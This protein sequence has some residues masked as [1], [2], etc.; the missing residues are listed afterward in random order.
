MDNTLLHKKRLLLFVGVVCAWQL[1]VLGKVFYLKVFQADE[2]ARQA[3]GQQED[4]IKVPATRGRI[5]DCRLEPLAASI[6]FDSVYVYT[7]E[8]QDKDTAARELGRVLGLDA[9]QILVKMNGPLKFRYIRRFISHE[10]AQQIQALNLAGVGLLQE[11]RRVY[12][13]GRLA[14]HILGA[15]SLRQDTE[16]GLEGLERQ[17]QD[18]LRGQP[19]ELFIQK[20]GR[21]NVLTTTTLRAPQGGH[22]LI[23]N[24]DSRI[25][26]IAQRELAAGIEAFNAATG[27]VIV[28]E[29]ETGRILALAAW[30][31][32]DP[33]NLKGTPPAN[34]RN[35]AVERYFEPGST[36]KIVTV[37]A[38]LEEEIASPDDVID[39][40][41]GY[42]SLSGHIIRDHR[43][44]QNL[45]FNEVL[46]NSSDVGAIKLGLRVG[47]E[48]LYRYIRTF[49]FG[50]RTDIDLPAEEPGR[51]QHHSG[52]SGISIGAISMGQEVGVTGVQM[53]RAMAV[54]A[55]GG[56]L[57]RPY[58]VDRVLDSQGRLVEREEPERVRVLSSRTTGIIRN[59]LEMVV[60]KGTGKKAAVAGYRVAG[61]TG[62]AQKYDPE[63]RTYSPTEF[64]SSYVGFAPA[65]HP[66]FVIAVIYDSPHPHYHGGDVSAPVFAE[67]ARQVLMLRKVEPTE[68]VAPERLAAVEPPPAAAPAAAP[69][70]APVDVLLPVEE[71]SRET[72]IAL[73][74]ENSF[75]M[76]DFT[77][78][79][80]RQ[81]MKECARIGLIL[82]PSGSGLA[83]EQIPPP[84]ALIKPSTRCT[85]WFTNEPHRLT[86][87]SRTGTLAPAADGRLAERQ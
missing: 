16:L 41:N 50:Q 28:M 45:S 71:A 79:S 75:T 67:I 17:Y 44:F 55:N 35:L 22:S 63:L 30:P 62:T 64:V 31:D 36:F 23:L 3:R 85:V 53:L 12:P 69:A 70:P 7:P 21:L 27:M 87:L 59:A 72:V 84:G 15:V 18:A 57:V 2:L 78:K 29:P 80:L 26:H 6:P 34:L 83:V 19:G 1:L 40:G 47:E 66:E 51:I 73:I 82:Q 24:I 43:A 60:S 14:S 4:I 38:A 32:F 81:V 74:P 49:G 48:G 13:N 9:R 10:E 8:I 58:V 25:Q 68:P 46:A 33:G 42:I 61:K 52:W 37:A 65:D 11:N 54:I 86:E 39:C 76:P 77:G 5:L 20:D 56:Y